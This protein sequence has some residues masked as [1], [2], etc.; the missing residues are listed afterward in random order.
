MLG[1]VLSHSTWNV[2]QIA[3]KQNLEKK[4]INLWP[5]LKSPFLKLLL[6]CGGRK[7]KIVKWNFIM[8][9]ANNSYTKQHN[10][11]FEGDFAPRIDYR[12]KMCTLQADISQMVV[13]FCNF[14]I[15]YQY[16]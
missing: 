7:V 16:L 5:N 4:T 13:R 8:C 9:L 1:A 14:D 10:I 15:F 11:I 3:S 12:C 2:E 6:Y